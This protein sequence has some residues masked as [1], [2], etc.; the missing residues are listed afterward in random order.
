MTLAN[1]KVPLKNP[2][3]VKHKTL[4]KLGLPIKDKARLLAI[5][6]VGGTADPAESSEMT[7][8]APPSNPQ[9]P[10]GNQQ[11]NNDPGIGQQIPQGSDPQVVVDGSTLTNNGAPITLSGKPVAFSSGT[12]RVGDQR[13]PISTFP[14]DRTPVSDLSLQLN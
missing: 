1:N 7:S 11:N 14:Q 12:I 4:S 9:E 13:E 3:L 6:G 10:S 5:H 2:V 8:A